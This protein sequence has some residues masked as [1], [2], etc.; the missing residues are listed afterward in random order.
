MTA[1]STPRH[2]YLILLIA[3]AAQFIAVVDVA[4]VN[5][6]LPS[7][8]SDLR[9]SESTLQWVVIAYSL[10][11]GSLLLLSGRFGDL[12]GKK[13]VLLVGL[14]VFTTASLFA[15]LAES[16]AELIAF[17]ALQGVGAAMIAPSALAVVAATFTEKKQRELALGI[18][19]ATGGAAASV[20]VIAGGVI[21]DGPGWSWIFFVN[22]PIGVALI[23]G[24]IVVLPRQLPQ[25]REHRLDLRSALAVT[26]GIVALL[27]GLSRGASEGWSS[28]Q[29]LGLF[30]VGAALLG[31]FGWIER[32][33]SAPLVP[34]DAL[35]NRPMLAADGAGLFGFGSFFAFIFL[36]TLLMQQML[37]YSPT[38]AGV[39][40]LITSVFA[41]FVAGAV[42]AVL[43]ARFGIWRLILVAMVAMSASGLWLMQIPDNPH[44][45]PNVVPAFLAAGLAIGIIGPGVQIA[46]LAG[47]EQ[48]RFGLA[49]GL[50][51]TM[52]ELGGAV[53][54]AVVATVALNGV[55]AGTWHGFRAGYVVIAVTAGLGALLAAVVVLRPA[56]SQAGAPEPVL[57]GTS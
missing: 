53:T 47:V 21:T 49:S 33:T 56:R 37:G 15:G 55:A 42:G 18:F 25:T 27:Y 20:G 13:P 32:R 28:P 5:V 14:T 41:F 48:A 45:G 22:L 39:A 54:S 57:V 50:V 7:I 34:A 52:R 8:A 43:A 26:A 31:L 1:T 38:K 4:I 2:R 24:A 3:A 29:V 40:W 9:L 19:G 16:S 11:F 36:T 35:R 51:E 44:F 30:A 6:A 46:A 10:P 12:V 17:R 23:A